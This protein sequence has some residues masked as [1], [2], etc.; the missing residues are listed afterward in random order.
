MIPAAPG[1]IG[2]YEVF[3]IS[4]LGLF[5]A[6]REEALALALVMHAWVLVVTTGLGVAS[7]GSSGLGFSRLV[8]LAGPA[9]P[10]GE[11]PSRGE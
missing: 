10:A 4:A 11:S 1:Y 8:S 5:G 2:T 6:T 7:L 3:T 9:H